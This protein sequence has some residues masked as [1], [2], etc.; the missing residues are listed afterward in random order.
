MAIEF[1]VKIDPKEAYAFKSS[2][3]VSDNVADWGISTVESEDRISAFLKKHAPVLKAKSYR[4]S[5]IP[6]VKEF[7][8]THLQ[9]NH[10]I[11]VEYHSN[12]IHSYDKETGNHVHDNLIERFDPEE[13]TVTAIDPWPWHRQRIIIPLDVL[14]R[15]ISTQYGRETGFIV[16]EKIP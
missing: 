14:E 11:W 12:E 15:A 3:P 10:D 5:S 8:I 2:M 6:S 1:G 4:Y 13:G 7:L 9:A 16:I